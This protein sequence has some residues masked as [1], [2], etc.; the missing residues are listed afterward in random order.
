MTPMNTT[1]ML[2]NI[3]TELK[4]TNGLL[5]FKWMREFHKK[6][7]SVIR[8][9]EIYV[10]TS[11]KWHISYLCEMTSEGAS[12]KRHH[13]PTSKGDRINSCG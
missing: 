11:V 9:D 6:G 3:N 7:S 1:E 8:M 10:T 13:P 12:N 2:I 5:N 4:Y